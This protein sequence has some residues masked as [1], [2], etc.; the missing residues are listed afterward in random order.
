M[1]GLQQV[2][3]IRRASLHEELV[4]T[5]RDI[6]VESEFQD[7]QKIPEKALCEQ[8]GVSRT[9]M[10]EALK[11]LAAEGLVT[12]VPNRGAVLR[13]LTRSD[14]DDLFPVIGA[15]EALAGELACERIADRE[16]ARIERLHQ[17]MVKAFEARKRSRYFQLNQEIHQAIVAAADNEVLAEQ[18][19]S[20]SVRLRRAR[21]IASRPSAR[22][23]R[24]VAEHDDIIRALKSRDGTALA[25][26]LRAHLADKH[27]SV[28]A[29]LENAEDAQDA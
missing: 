19:R 16:I 4:A 25:T 6:L 14:I 2:P 23:D 26:I 21:F 3:A 1:E 24:A 17:R 18:Y 10:R 29:Q 13:G 5:L 8:L 7:G 15:L 27:A 20:L 28:V 11:V 12:L 9:P 22:W